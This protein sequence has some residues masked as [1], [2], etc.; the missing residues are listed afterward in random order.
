MILAWLIFDVFESI[1]HFWSDEEDMND[2]L[3]LFALITFTKC[4]VFAF[5]AKLQPLEPEVVGWWE[6]MPFGEEQDIATITRF[7]VFPVCQI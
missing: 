4:F 6:V 7:F 3:C 1:V 2:L 5:S